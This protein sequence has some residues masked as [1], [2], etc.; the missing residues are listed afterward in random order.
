[1]YRD[2]LDDNLLSNAL[3]ALE[4]ILLSPGQP[5]AHSQNNKTVALRELGE[6]P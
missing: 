1:M 5:K 3:D 4:N 2:I 6:C